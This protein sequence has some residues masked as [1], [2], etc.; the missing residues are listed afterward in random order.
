[1]LAASA[2]ILAAAPAPSGGIE[3]FYRAVA[4]ASFTLLGLWWVVV[5]SRYQRGEGALVAR[6]HAYGIALFFLLPGIMSLIASINS[7]VSALWRVAFGAC[8][9]IGLTEV[10]LYLR[11]QGARSAV[12]LALRAFGLALYALIGAVAIHPGLVAAAGVGLTPQELESVLLGLLLFVGA[13]LVWLGLTE[14]LE[15]AGA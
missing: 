3:S 5:Q 2:D 14:P 13:N 6:R 9:A 8:A 10:A 12:A 11:T 4:T 1:M 15:A 7:E